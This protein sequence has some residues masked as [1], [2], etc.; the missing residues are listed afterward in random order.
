MKVVG[1][2][3]KEKNVAAVIMIINMMTVVQR[4][5]RSGAEVG[6]TALDKIYLSL[7]LS[8]SP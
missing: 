3:W 7:H 6:G 4:D 2:K 5:T 8:P 1:D